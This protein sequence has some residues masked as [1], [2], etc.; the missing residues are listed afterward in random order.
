[1]FI[2]FNEVSKLYSKSNQTSLMN[3][4]ISIIN[5]IKDEEDPIKKFH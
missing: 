4:V 2:V 5:G 3:D 1:M